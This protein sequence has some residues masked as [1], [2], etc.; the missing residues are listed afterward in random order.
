MT[1][2]SDR[3]S[4]DRLAGQRAQA[5]IDS[6]AQ[7]WTIHQACDALAWP[8]PTTDIQLRHFAQLCDTWGVHVNVDNESWWKRLQAEGGTKP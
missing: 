3:T 4:F 6:Q 5:G 8:Y 7:N 2:L 1:L